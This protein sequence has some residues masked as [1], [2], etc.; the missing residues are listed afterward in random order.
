MTEDWIRAGDFI[1]RKWHRVIDTVIGD[2]TVRTVPMNHET[3]EIYPEYL[4][5]CKALVW[6]WGQAHNDNPPEEERCQRCTQAT[7]G[8]GDG[9]RSP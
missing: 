5:A 8:P 1:K 6:T 2:P 7:R 9:L 4:T 3:G